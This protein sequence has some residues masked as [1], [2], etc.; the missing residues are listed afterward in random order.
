MPLT[1]GGIAVLGGYGL[2]LGVASAL[3]LGAALAPT[4]PVWASDIQ[5]GPPNLARRM[6]SVLR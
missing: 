3:L 6:R 1:I 5:V 4:D 2:G